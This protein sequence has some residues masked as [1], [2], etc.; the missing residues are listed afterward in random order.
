MAMKL[1][2]KVTKSASKPA[3]LLSEP[4][5]RPLFSPPMANR[6]VRADYETRFELLAELQQSNP[7]PDHK[8]TVSVL[9]AVENAH[10]RELAKAREKKSVVIEITYGQ[11]DETTGQ[12]IRDDEFTA[13]K[14]REDLLEQSEQ[15]AKQQAD[16]TQRFAKLS[17]SLPRAVESEAKA[18]T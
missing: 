18:G 1:R 11:R 5:K 10:A 4:Q 6:Y 3:E 12:W 17:A 16:I 7:D 8:L 13:E 14:A 15:L 9:C 2:K